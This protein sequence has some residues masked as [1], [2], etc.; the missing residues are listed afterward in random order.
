MSDAAF[1]RLG[2]D[3]GMCCYR[4]PTGWPNRAASGHGALLGDVRYGSLQSPEVQN[5]SRPADCHADCAGQSR[6][7]FFSHSVRERRCILCAACDL[8]DSVDDL[9]C[10]TRHEDR[11]K[12]IACHEPRSFT[13]WARVAAG[14]AA[15]R[16]ER[17]HG[18]AR[19]TLAPLLQGAYSVRLYGAA[20]RVPLGT[21]RLVWLSL[22]ADTSPEALA[23]VKAMGV[24]RYEPRPPRQP[25]Y[26][27]IDRDAGN[28]LD[29][30]WVH[31]PR[32]PFAQNNSWVEI[33]HCPKPPGKNER[34]LRWMYLPMW[35]YV[36]PGSG[37]S[38]NV[39]RT[40]VMPTFDALVHVLHKIFPGRLS[41]ADRNATG[42][43]GEAAHVLR[44]PPGY[45]GIDSLQ[46]DHTEGWARGLRREIVLIR[47][48]ECTQL[49]P[50]DAGVRC[51]RHPHL[52]QCA[53]EDLARMSVAA[54]RNGYRSVGFSARVKAALGARLWLS[55]FD[56]H[57][58]CSHSA[59]YERNGSAWCPADATPAAAGDG[60]R[61]NVL[62]D[63]WRNSTRH[64]L[65]RPARERVAAAGARPRA[66]EFLGSDT[67]PRSLPPS[68]KFFSQ[69]V[70]CCR[71]CVTPSRQTASIAVR[72]AKPPSRGD[73]TCV[74]PV[75][76]GGVA[77]ARSHRATH[78][79]RL[80]A[81]AV[82]DVA[83]QRAVAAGRA[84]WPARRHA[85]AAHALI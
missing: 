61:A 8:R 44:R 12:Y 65:S 13:A 59:C 74:S 62:R 34:G 85:E 77:V 56:P 32:L 18:V 67:T 71:G 26:S 42:C 21:L 24:C 49:V 15:P 27:H 50:A 53:E 66:H 47:P 1:V 83:E 20:H 73:L 6:C 69:T 68:L 7:R 30:M 54:C 72:H 16:Y 70:F 43:A 45:E 22:L 2:A 76:T 35:G 58:P 48:A 55:R 79:W 60:T 75:A 17:V 4:I 40:R 78:L 51:G 80:Q 31:Q 28:P 25:F 29:A 81:A 9:R 63:S 57:S 36:A 11:R 41:P 82:A 5:A 46:A 84:I 14:A 19:R 37:V 33:V 23:A 52:R 10:N 38:V 39:G 3:G 64:A